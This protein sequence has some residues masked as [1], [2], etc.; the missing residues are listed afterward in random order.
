VEREPHG[1]V[2]LWLVG[3]RVTTLGIA[4][5]VVVAHRL[6]LSLSLC[7]S[8]TLTTDRWLNTN[9]G[10]K[11]VGIERGTYGIIDD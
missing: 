5:I 9:T 7:L 3:T 6:S 11:R 10:M 2:A 1:L 4:Y 8:L